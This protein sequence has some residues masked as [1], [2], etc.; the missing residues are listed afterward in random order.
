MNLIMM[1]FL[2]ALLCIF[3]C[4]IDLSTALVSTSSNQ[5]Q[6]AS[7]KSVAELIRHGGRLSKLEL[8]TRMQAEGP[9]SGADV[10][11][12]LLAG[13]TG[14]RMKADRPKQF[15][16]LRGK[17]VLDHTLE[18]FLG[19][20]YV[21][22]LVL[23]LA[24]QYR[25]EY[26]PYADRD[27]RVVFADPG[28]E[29]QDSVSNGLGAVGAGAALVAVHDAARPLVTPG[30]I[31]RVVA[32]ARA[33]GAAVL[34]VPMKA[35]V[36][37]SADGEFVLRTIPRARLW[38]IQ[39]PQV[40]KPDLLREGFRKVEAEGLEVTD[41]VSIIEAL[42]LPVKITMG[43]YTNLK[44]TTPDDMDVAESILQ[45]REAAAAK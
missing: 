29:R 9:A 25:G 22:Q 3:F 28:K 5:L 13:G 18:L 11:V 33:H 4:S 17:P 20:P 43:E 26:Q 10:A 38:E 40:I 45:A 19:L 15:L 31:A 1:K 14:S 24:E 30:N 16:G 34:G 8:T 44:L 27:A 37:E 36:K 42:G 21:S 39:T 35:T 41:D 7:Q 2:K 6:S 32:D 23:V 12:I